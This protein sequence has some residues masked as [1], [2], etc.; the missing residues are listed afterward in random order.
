M[1]GPLPARI[2]WILSRLAVPAWVAAGAI[3]KLREADVRTLPRETILSG[4]LALNIH[5][6]LDYLLAVLIG[7]EILAVA[8][9]LFVSRL[10]RPMA[11]FV[12]SVFCL[13]L[14]GELV[15]GNFSSC[16]CFGD[17]P[18]PPWAMLIVDGALLFGVVILDPSA[19]MPAKPPS[20][21]VGLAVII[22]VAGFVGSFWRVVYGGSAPP[23]LPAIVE[24]ASPDNGGRTN[25]GE[26]DGGPPVTNGG[27]VN[28]VDPV[29]PVVPEDPTINPA[30]TAVPKFYLT[31]DVKDWE[32]QPWRQVE[33]FDFM[34]KWP[35]DLDRGKRYVTFFGRNCD[36]C[37]DMFHL[38]LVDPALASMTTAVQVPV[39]KTS[40]L[41]ENPWPMP[42]TNCEMLEL[43]LGC[44]WLFTTPLTLTI[45]DGIVTCAREGDHTECMGLESPD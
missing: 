42:Q 29:T 30:P 10:A 24:D 41:G 20:W 6:H 38:D 7:L 31:D 45:E 5:N 26:P 36:H 43:P 19:V 2:G 23:W 11:I 15:Q 12:L 21:P 4:A 44:D 14:L 18:I 35:K 8:V 27:Q 34:A 25:G 9:M 22:A 40:R 28:G 17:V 3:F 1:Q 32:G 37:D 13:I 39:N 16:G 33:L